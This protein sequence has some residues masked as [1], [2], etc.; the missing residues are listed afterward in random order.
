M[1]KVCD[2]PTPLGVSPYGTHHRTLPDEPP[3]R[4]DGSFQTRY[5]ALEERMRALAEDDGDIYLPN[6]E[7]EGPVQYVLIC[8]EPSLGHWARSAE[9]ARARVAAGFRNFLTSME[10]MI[11]HFCVRH[12]LCG[13]AERYHI[14]DFSKGAMLVHRANVAR[15]ER[16][17]RWYTLLLEEIDLV[18]TPNAGIIAVGNLVA[19]NL[20]ERGFPRPF[21]QVLHY[22][23]QAGPA[24]QRAILGREASFEAF[25]G[26]VS[27]EHFLATAEDVLRA[28]HAGDKLRAETLSQL[29]RSELT[30]SRQQL[31]FGYKM[32]FESM[33]G[34]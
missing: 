19:W 1:T 9:E 3:M 13:P 26:S 6:P 29:R 25:K 2:N 30:T 10:A 5:R 22:S 16:Y 12:Y 23:G 17:E 18:A 14:T 31:I 33:R 15:A 7:P 34:P 11:L 8:M 24:R 32:D 4:I 21:T 28:A 27:L 20:R